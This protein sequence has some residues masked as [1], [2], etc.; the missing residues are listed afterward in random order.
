M[1]LVIDETNIHVGI[2]SVSLKKKNV[3]D[4]HHVLMSCQMRPLQCILDK[5]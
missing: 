4:F 2:R 3:R 5:G 1:V